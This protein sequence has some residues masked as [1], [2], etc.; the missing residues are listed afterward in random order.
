LKDDTDSLLAT[1]KSIEGGLNGIMG[2]KAMMTSSAEAQMIRKMFSERMREFITDDSL[3]ELLLPK[4]SV[5]CRRLTP[6]CYSVL[7][8]LYECEIDLTGYVRVIRS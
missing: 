7:R 4:F 3:Y 5:G 1:A 2:I 6:V 8:A